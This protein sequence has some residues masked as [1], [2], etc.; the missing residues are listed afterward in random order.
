VIRAGGNWD[1][2]IL[3]RLIWIIR[4]GKFDI[5][6][7][8]LIY[9]QIYGRLAAIGARAKRIVSSE[10]NVYNFKAR[11]PFLW[12]ERRLSAWTDRIVACSSKVRE[13]L[14]ER[15]GISPLKVVV[16]PNGVDTELFFPIKKRSRLYPKVQRVREE[17]GL[18]AEDLVIGTVGHMS[19]QKGHEVLVAAMP[20][21]LK[22]YPKAKFVFVGKG[23]LR[24]KVQEQARRLGVEAAIR[25]A[26]LREDVPVVLN[27]FDVFALP[28]LW[29]GFGTAIIEAMACGV[30]VV[31]S[32]VG[33]VPE[34]I[35]E[36]TNGLLVPPG[37]PGPLADAIMR[38]L[39]D[40]KLRRDL[41]YHGL[42]SA[43]SRFGVTRMVQTMVKLYLQL[44]SQW[45]PPKREVSEW[46]DT[47]VTSTV[48]WRG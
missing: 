3:P 7:T 31:A 26:G 11:Y 15:V 9:S 42:R 37:H 38:L 8:H 20:R 45:H 5:V 10:Q 2:S 30:P 32:R 33:G 22:K 17:L 28:S 6:H 12:I 35:D 39:D 48:A 1:V 18:G 40:R 16:V 34:L 47:T 14:I 25:F 24:A 44:V 23:K 4:K 41:I 36:G 27:S 29:E 43:V 13:H 19:R 46:R 21:I